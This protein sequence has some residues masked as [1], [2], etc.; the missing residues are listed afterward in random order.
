MSLS[1][2]SPIAPQT[3]TEVWSQQLELLGV[4]A[5]QLRFFSPDGQRVP[6]AAEGERQQKELAQQRAERLAAKL[7][8][9]GV[10]PDSL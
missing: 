10:D 8:E 2:F 3:P 5:N 6:T 7:R 1:K 9:L 4:D